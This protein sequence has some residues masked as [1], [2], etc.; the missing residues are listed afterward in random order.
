MIHAALAGFLFTLLPQ[1]PPA[2]TIQFAK[3]R[4]I[5]TGWPDL[6]NI[7]FIAD[8]DGDKFGDLVSVNLNDRGHIEF[9]RNVRGGKLGTGAIGADLPEGAKLEPLEQISLRRTPGKRPE[10]L[11]QRA[12]GVIYH[13]Q[14]PESGACTITTEQPAPVEQPTTKPAE[15]APAAS[16]PAPAAPVADRVMWRRD[17]TNI[18][19]DFDGDG[20]LDELV[21]NKIKF[22]SGAPDADVPFLREL[23]PN[24]KIAHGDFQGDG[25]DDILILRNDSAW[26]SG[27]DLNIYL[28]C[29]PQDNDWDGDGLDNKR[30]EA[31]KS[32]PLDADTDHDGL[33]DG[34]EVLGEGALDLPQLGASPIHKDCVVYLQR[35]DTTNPDNAKNDIARAV[36]YWSK[37]PVKNPDGAPGIHLITIW[38]GPLD[39][40]VHGA[41]PWWTLGDENLPQAAA[42]LAHYIIISPGGGGQSSELGDKGG[43][44][45]GALYAT[46]LHEFGHQVGLGHAGGP[47][48][49]MCPTYSSL[50]NYPY[51]YGFNDDY[52]QIHYSN[53]ELASLVLNKAKLREHVDVP[54]EKLKFLEKGPWR[55]KLRADGAA[56]WVDWN[57]NGQFDEGVIRADITDTYGVD[58]GVRHPAGKTV[59]APA[60]A[61]HKDQLFL[62]GVSREKKLFIKKNTGEG[63]WDP[64]L[65]LPQI[66][67]AGDPSM[68]SD[69][70]KIYLYIPVANGVAMLSAPE[71]GGLAAAQPELLDGSADCAVSAAIYQKRALILLWRSPDQPVRTLEQDPNDKFTILRQIPGSE[72][73]NCPSAAE[74]TSTGEL[75]LGST[76]ITKENNADKR[77]WRL[78]RFARGGNGDF[79]LTKSEWVGGAA[80]GWVGNSRPV[81]IYESGKDIGPRGRVHFMGVGW[82]DAPNF[83]G[84]FYEAI[85][86][87]DASQNDGWRLR[88]FYD[89]WT[90]SR[91]PI[92]AV[93]HNNDIALAFR[94][95]G[96]VHGDDDD[97]LL[98]SHHAL[99][100]TDADMRDFDD[101]TEIAE[102]GLAHSIPWRIG[103]V[104]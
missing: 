58:G 81:I 85:T 42:G 60:L 88:R 59:F 97:N 23:T 47:L 102:V 63:A 29:L 36:A 13:F 103:T 31:L 78:S 83:N 40:K 89:E 21:Q 49:G 11:F 72:C 10:L 94:W 91:S 48:P 90:T 30:E 43:C 33:L 45:E 74:D 69:G 37:L 51:S 68:I 12:D 27:R 39:S 2:P 8:M 1:Q 64:E 76:V 53:G 56:T 6:N 5:A 55:L 61:V 34:W 77:R 24:A 41:K 44:G 54:Y 73:N 9:A 38:L 4:F 66:A 3:P 26:R 14:Y 99:G 57:R 101:I 50:M 7:I 67:P 52:N 82:T 79:T 17:F 19:G 18:H 35:Q 93:W 92:G 65:Y 32:D 87:G 84:C 71:A 70:A 80:A 20:K 100:I 16:G 15:S 86:I 62:A 75:L 98:V 104:K 46:F 95:F 25:K 22:A 96:N 28:S